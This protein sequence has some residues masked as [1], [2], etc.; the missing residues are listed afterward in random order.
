MYFIDLS[1]Y[2]ATASGNYSNWVNDSII[3]G[4]VG[5]CGWRGFI[6]GDFED[7]MT[8][9]RD[10]N[11]T[12]YKGLNEYFQASLDILDEPSGSTINNLYYNEFFDAQ[13][14]YL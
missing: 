10:T 12:W 8:T 4:Y 1:D 3:T 5:L 2:I 11:K 6:S 14:N 9:A 7:F 13:E